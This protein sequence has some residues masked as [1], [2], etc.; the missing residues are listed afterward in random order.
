MSS[1]PTHQFLSS[2]EKL[3]SMGLENPWMAPFHGLVWDFAAN[4]DRPQTELL[5]LPKFFPK[6]EI[7]KMKRSFSK[8]RSVYWHT[9]LTPPPPDWIYNQQ[10]FTIDMIP[11]SIYDLIETELTYT[12]FEEDY[13]DEH[14]PYDD[15][16]DD[17]YTD[18]ESEDEWTD[19]QGELDY[20]PEEDW[21]VDMEELNAL[22][23]AL[24]GNRPF[25]RRLVKQQKQDDKRRKNER[26]LA[27]D[28]KA[29]SNSAW[30]LE[31]DINQEQHALNGNPGKGK[32]RAQHNPK[33]KQAFKHKLENAKSMEKRFAKLS[34]A[35]PEQ[36]MEIDEDFKE[37]MKRA[38]REPVDDEDFEELNNRH[39]WLRKSLDQLERRER[40]EKEA[41]GE[42]VQPHPPIPPPPARAGNNVPQN[43]ELRQPVQIMQPP[44]QQGR[45]LPD[46]LDD[47]YILGAD[48]LFRHH[49]IR[50]PR[51]PTYVFLPLHQPSNFVVELHNGEWLPPANDMQDPNNDSIHYFSL[52]EGLSHVV[53]QMNDRVI[54]VRTQDYGL[55]IHYLASVP[56]RRDLHCHIR[57]VDPEYNF[58][59]KDFTALCLGFDEA[60]F[61]TP[62]N[63]FFHPPPDL[64]PG[65]IPIPN[66]PPLPDYLQARR[67]RLRGPGLMARG[68]PLPIDLFA[69]VNR[70]RGPDFRE[71]YRL[72]CPKKKTIRLHEA[73]GNDESYHR[74]NFYFCACGCTGTSPQLCRRPTL[75]SIT[76]NNVANRNGKTKCIYKERPVFHYTPHFAETLDHPSDWPY[77][78]Y[79]TTPPAPSPRQEASLKTAV[80]HEGLP[81]DWDRSKQLLGRYSASSAWNLGNNVFS[82]AVHFLHGVYRLATSKKPESHEIYKYQLPLYPSKL[83]IEHLDIDEPPQEGPDK[84]P[85]FHNDVRPH[86]FRGAE[87]VVDGEDQIINVKRIQPISTF[88][89]FRTRR[90]KVNIVQSLIETSQ[91]KSAEGIIFEEEE[92]EMTIEKQTLNE[93]KT[94]RVSPDSTLIHPREHHSRLE[95]H[96]NSI[97]HI[98]TDHR[99]GKIQNTV[100]LTQLEGATRFNNSLVKGGFRR[101][102]LH[103][104]S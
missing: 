32:E 56:H 25:S 102:P 83:L 90:K 40:E 37:R 82:S 3:E 18:E 104:E 60:Q 96:S 80:F 26:N 27:R 100:L 31:R 10:G 79:S 24:N 41:E 51:E 20:A 48:C 4:P 47:T 81:A 85:T 99:D 73:G 61:G 95:R 19:D 8:D 34:G 33:R 58:T 43:V 15:T 89:F 53:A 71:A 36:L 76:L 52:P 21:D 6:H 64:T 13:D 63:Q 74:N 84:Q 35:S 23:H 101:A 72:T 44:P 29:Y 39:N 87:I 57:I 22:A 103:A 93:A 69:G 12:D 49:Q 77:T 65:Q 9:L 94:T 59:F 75:L 50:I 17:Y 28:D 88:E 98:N 46:G 86:N 66:S 2:F 70:V 30:L 67:I 55:L 68:E 97:S 45:W 1:L 62:I 78:W 91:A 42:E 14:H 5:V 54:T 38:E 11:E 7:W 16:D 92:T